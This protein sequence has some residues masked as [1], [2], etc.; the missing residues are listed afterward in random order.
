MKCTLLYILIALTNLSYGQVRYSQVFDNL[1]VRDM[2]SIQNH[3]LLH[4]DHLM[5]NEL[6]KYIINCDKTYCMEGLAFMNSSFEYEWIYVPETGGI[7][8]F[9]EDANYIYILNSQRTNSKVNSSAK[10]FLLKINRNGKLISSEKIDEIDF[11]RPN[12]SFDA[13]FDKNGLIWKITDIPHGVKSDYSKSRP[14]TPGKSYV[15]EAL[16]LN[17]KKQATYNIDGKYL[18]FEA[19]DSKTDQVSFVFSADSTVIN[20]ELLQGDNNYA[21]NISSI[22]LLQFNSQVELITSKYIGSG[23]CWIKDIKYQGDNLIIGGTYR[24]NDSILNLPDC[25]LLGNRLTTPKSYISDGLARNSFIASLD[26]NLKVNWLNKISGTCDILF[27]SLSTTNNSLAISFNYKDSVNISGSKIYS[28]KTKSKYQYA[29]P[30]ICIFDSKGKLISHEQLACHSSGWN[31][32]Y[33]FPN[34]TAIHGTFLSNMKVY[35]NR[36]KSRSKNSVYY[37]TFIENEKRL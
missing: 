5:Y 10:L 25:F 28:L 9:W 14:G 19:F 26:S 13:K 15:I 23:S 31:N 12:G 4:L 17:L 33:I 3:Y 2:K 34:Y 18:Y 30:I 37:L 29:D 36:L 22:L 35:R 32:V 1:L 11:N 7:T 20:N 21:N 8:D 27:S 24:G 16:N 6:K